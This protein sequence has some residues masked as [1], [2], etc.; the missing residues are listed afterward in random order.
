MN[1]AL[2][3][4]QELL[5]DSVSKLLRTESTPVRV[6]AAEPLGHDPVLWASLVAFGIPAMRAFEAAGGGG[7]GLLDAVLVAEEVGR[8]LASAPVIESIVAAHL[9]AELGGEGQAWFE[10]VRDGG[11]IVTLALHEAGLHPRQIVPGG[12]VADAI[13]YLDDD[14]VVLLA[15]TPRGTA[16]DNLGKAPLA[17]ID[18]EGGADGRTRHILAH[19]PDARYAYLAALE[20]WKILTAAALTGLGRRALEMAAEYAS[21][22]EAFGRLIGTYQ[23][24]SHPLADSITDID[25]AQLLT[26]RAVWAMA[27]GRDDAAA[28]VSMA[29]WWAARSTAT[30]VVR[31]LRTFGGYGLSVEYDIQLYFRRG[32]AMALP[33][34]DP[35]A[36]LGRVADRLWGDARWSP[37]PDPGAVDIEFGYG[38]AAEQFA[39][40]IQ[41]F[42]DEN[43]TR[44][45]REAMRRSL[46]GY[47]PEMQRK[48]AEAGFLYPDW[49]VEYGGQG[50][51]AYQLSALGVVYEANDWSRVAIGT[52][53]MGARM[54]MAFGSEALRQ[55]ALPRFAAGTASSCLGFTE[56]SCGSDV[57]AARTR[58]VR[59]GDDWIIN[60]QKVFTTA[61]HVS[62]YVLLLTRSDPDA[63]KHKGLTMFLVPMGL[64]GIAVEALHTMQEE[65]TNI[66]YYADVRVPDMYRLGPVN[67]AV[68][69]MASAMKLEHSGEGYHISHP[70]LV[71]AAVAWA[72]EAIDESGRRRIDDPDVRARIAQAAVHNEV[73]DLL[74][75]RA[76]WAGVEGVP[77]RAFGPM[78]KLFTTETYM[79]DS[80]DLLELAAPDSLLEGHD[81]LGVLEY[82]HRHSVGSTIYGGTSEVHRSVIAETSLGLPRTRA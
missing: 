26:W 71:E 24:V 13:L 2:T 29:F 6:R 37:L 36:E 60:G 78:S 20:E 76:V 80:A 59:E 12:G 77:S 82:K 58:A 53:N 28:S 61:A 40:E 52:T 47:D 31:A 56:P 42:F 67:G 16:R 66:T 48:L 81:P 39:A 62:D 23:G 68:G 45:R 75:R 64:P 7:M 14:E 79:K 18:L 33:L 44:E 27:R 9:L 41:Q 72:H 65:R 74:C 69:V 35:K 17:S 10:R 34:G 25:G 19:G 22:R 43:L 70:A 51:S 55:E 1:L 21:E 8:H 11:A 57:F 49:P 73:A 15:G 54:A 3:P 30:A 38:E 4:E 50:R 63:P 32:R 5:R 46:D